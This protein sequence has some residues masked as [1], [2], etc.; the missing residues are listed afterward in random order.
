[1][2]QGLE[3]STY[4]IAASLVGLALLAFWQPIPI[5]IWT[6]SGLLEAFLWGAF[7]SGWLLLFLSAV[8]F[9]IFELLGVRQ[10][11]AWSRGKPSPAPTLKTRGPYRLFRHPMY[12]GVLLG[13]WATPHMTAGHLLLAT[14]F[15]IYILIARR[16]E[17]RDLRRT[18]GTAYAA[19]PASHRAPPT[20]R[21]RS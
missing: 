13:L 7:A 4:V 19:Q 12:V 21:P 2:P 16:Y 10:A 1:V 14:A 18:F 17:E 9:D 8:S 5:V 3:R 15:T 11:V 20:A 6:V